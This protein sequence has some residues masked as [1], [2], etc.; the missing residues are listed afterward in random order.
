MDAE[1]LT[2]GE[3]QDAYKNARS[4]WCGAHGFQKATHNKEL[5]KKYA[6]ELEKRK[7]AIPT[8]DGQF[9]GFGSY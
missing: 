4:T 3:L 9:N 7:I 6:K 1:K 2:D 8:E 5:A